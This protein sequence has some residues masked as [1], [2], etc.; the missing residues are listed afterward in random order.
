MR[1]KLFLTCCILILASCTP[2]LRLNVLQPAEISIPPHIYSIGLVNRSVAGKSDRMLNVLEGILTGENIGEDR[3]GGDKALASLKA[4]LDQSERYNVIIPAIPPALKAGPLTTAEVRSICQQY[5]LDAL[6]VLEYFDSNSSVNVSQQKKKEKVKEQVVETIFFRA[7]AQLNVNTRWTVYDDS[8]GAI[9]DMHDS[10]DYLSFTNDG[11]TPELAK[12][13]LPQKRYA[14]NRTGQLAGANYGARIAPYWI[15]VS[16]EYFRKGSDDLKKAASYSKNGIWAKAIEIW[17]KEST[18]SNP[19][20]A[21]RANYNMAIACEREG[22]VELALV[23]AKK[24]RDQ[25]ANAKA[26]YY[27]RVL[28]RRLADQQKLDQQ[29]QHK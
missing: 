25:Y 18:N 16:R 27:A 6:V 21:G 20:I 14:I 8:T 29:L 7:D 24:S 10:E 12:A 28:E 9:I 19:E 13:G 1:T 17:K 4:A 3:E 5:H 23:Y 26:A 2:T 22:N 15:T 11:N